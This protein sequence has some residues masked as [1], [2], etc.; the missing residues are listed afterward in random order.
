MVKQQFSVTIILLKILMPV[1]FGEETKE[2][3]KILGY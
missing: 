2:Q 1:F 3:A